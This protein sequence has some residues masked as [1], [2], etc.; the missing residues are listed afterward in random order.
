MKTR[1]NRIKFALLGTAVLCLAALP[2]L[3]DVPAGPG[4]GNYPEPGTLNYIQGSANL[5]GKPLNNQSVGRTQMSQGQVLRTQN[6]KAEVLLTPGVFLRVD[7]R[8]SVKMIS[9]NLTNTRVA[10]QQG[11]IG[12]EVDEIHPQNDLQIVDNGVTTQLLKRGFYEFIASQPK[13][14]V[15]SGEAQVETA[16]GTAQK[17]KKHHEMALLAGAQARPHRFNAKDAQDNLYNWSKLRSQYLAEANNRYASQYGWGQWGGYPGWY[18]NPWAL[19]WDWAWG[20]GWGPGWG[21][22][23][24][25]NPWWGPGYGY[26]GGYTVPLYHRHFDYDSHPG[27]HGHPGG[28]QGGFH[29]GHGDFNHSLHGVGGFHNA[30]PAG[31]SFHAGGRG[32]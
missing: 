30:A 14:L 20:S 12:I 17:V 13:V 6:G 4:N 7:N 25:W 32:H 29:G 5:A 21:F 15:F 19:D 8:S 28:H 3:A 27:F 1:I 26:W 11:E 10:L 16:A 24:G 22:G 23:W 9:P 31:H 18:W 2:A